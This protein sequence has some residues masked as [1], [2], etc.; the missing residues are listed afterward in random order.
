M[1]LII[2]GI[3]GLQKKKKKK[4]RRLIKIQATAANHKRE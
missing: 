4:G 1:K 2:F 3:N